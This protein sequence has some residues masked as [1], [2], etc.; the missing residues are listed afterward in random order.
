MNDVEKKWEDLLV[1]LQEQLDDEINLKGVLYLIGVQE[2]NQDIRSYS[3]EEKINLM[4]IAVCKLL[5]P[6]GYFEFE[7]IDEDGWPHWKELKAVKNLSVKE[8]GLLIKKA[9]LVYFN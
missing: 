7:K 9:V 6:F 2:L 4:H 8:Q 3:K 1:Q 5:S